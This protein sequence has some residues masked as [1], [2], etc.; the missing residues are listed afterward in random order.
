MDSIKL[1]LA[2]CSWVV[3]V[4]CQADGL[5]SSSYF[6]KIRCRF[7]NPK[8]CH[9]VHPPNPC[10]TV[11]CSVGRR[12]V[13]RFGKGVCILRNPL[14]PCSGVKCP[15]GKR[16]IVRFGKG[17]CIH[18]TPINPCHYTKCVAGKRCI[19]ISRRAVCV[20][21]YPINLCVFKRCPPGTR[22]YVR[23]GRAVCLRK[24]PDPCLKKV[25]P[26]GKHCVRR[27]SLGVCLPNRSVCQEPLKVGPCRAAIRRYYYNRTTGRCQ[28]FFWGG[29]QPNGNNFSSYFQCYRTCGK[30]R[31]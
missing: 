29:C 30:F 15:A 31:G 2:V 6:C 16:C 9:C 26:K 13:V 8:G 5:V 12:C 11:K 25:C 10:R 14:N 3:F 17:V 1:L 28:R 27:G 20:P 7:G 19:V 24:N 23:F 4:N 21:R 18:K 22:C